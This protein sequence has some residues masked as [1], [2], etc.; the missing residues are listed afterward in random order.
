MIFVAMFA[1][2]SKKYRP[3]YAK[4]AIMTYANIGKIYTFK[5]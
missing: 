4:N 3:I 1:A 2:K 5:F